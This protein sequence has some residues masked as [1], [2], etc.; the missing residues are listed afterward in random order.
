MRRMVSFP[1]FLAF[2]VG[3]FLNLVGYYHPPLVAEV[4]G[5]LSRPFSIIALI[6]IGLQMDLSLK[7]WQTKPLLV[8]MTYKL[9]LA[10]LII[11]ILCVTFADPSPMVLEI[12]VIGAAMGS[13]NTVAIIAI[14]SKLNPP[15]AAQMV[16]IS[17][18]LSFLIIYLIHWLLS[19]FPM[20]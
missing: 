14:R 16:G 19:A 12:T 6:A 10:P 1:P 17:I 3:L 8:G 11:Y 18:P 5:Q 20:I 7:G 2:L 15:L 13:M 9:L 4:L